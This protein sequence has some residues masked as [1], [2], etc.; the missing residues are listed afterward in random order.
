MEAF[1]NKINKNSVIQIAKLLSQHSSGFDEKVFIKNCHSK[2]E[3]LELKQRVALISEQMFLHLP[4]TQLKNLTTIRKAC[5]DANLS[6]FEFW[7]FSDYIAKYT[8]EHFDESLDVLKE[9]TSYFSSEFA[10]RSY[11]LADYQRCLSHFKEWIKNDCHHIRRLASEGSRPLLPWGQKLNLFVEQPDICFFILDQLVNDES[12]YVRKSVANHMNDHSKNHPDWVVKKLKNWKQ[13]HKNN[14]NVEWVI[15]HSS[16]SLIKK[17]FSDAFA[18]H[19]VKLVKPKVH[20]QKILTSKVKLGDSLK[21]LL[22]IQNTSNEKQKFILDHELHLLKANN[23]HN[24]K[25]FKAKKIDLDA[26]QRIKLELS[27]PIKKVTTRKYY[28]GVHYWNIKINS[29]SYEKL[30]F[31]L[32]MKKS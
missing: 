23:K 20:Q 13:K 29:F 24:I 19:D 30:K 7:P 18:L 12:E 15:K 2:I 5:A 1:K 26:G 31:D 21:I 28:A 3:N 14:S 32:Q 10:V 17:G 27:L 6:A 25:C 16:R 4:K 8:L 22:E 11:F 9:I